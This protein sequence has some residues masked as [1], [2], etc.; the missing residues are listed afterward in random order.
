MLQ[1]CPGRV[2][3]PP[4]PYPA[5]WRPHPRLRR[6]LAKSQPRPGLV[7]TGFGNVATSFRPHANLISTTHPILIPA[8]SQGPRSQAEAQLGDVPT[9]S[10]HGPT[11]FQPHPSR[12][13]AVSQ[14]R[15]NRSDRKSQVEPMPSRAPHL[16]RPR[17]DRVR[18]SRRTRAGAEP[19]DP[20]DRTELEPSWS[21]A[22][23]EPDTIWTETRAGGFTRDDASPHILLPTATPSGAPTRSLPPRQHLG[24]GGGARRAGVV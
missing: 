23:A 12:L 8:T 3:A 11:A 17:W 24:W 6:S 22:G 5:A 18:R 21:G 16:S 1:A 9:S 15:P 13:L 20:R 2:P 19:L 14:P 10:G 7:L 4:W